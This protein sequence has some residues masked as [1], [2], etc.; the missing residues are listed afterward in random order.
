MRANSP[1]IDTDLDISPP[2]AQGLLPFLPRFWREYVEQSSFK[3]PVEAPFGTVARPMLVRDGLRPA[4]SRVPGADLGLLREQALDAWGATYGILNCAYEVDSIHNPDAAA[5][6]A[7]A[8]NDWQAAEWLAHEPRLRASLVVPARWPELAAREVR[9]WAGRPGFVQ[10]LLPAR[11]ESPYGN[12]RYHPLYAAAV[13]QGLTIG[14]HFGGEPGNPP[15]ASGW[16]SYGIEEYVGMASVF[17]SQLISLV[18][19]GAF[20]QFPGLRVALLEG[21]FTW[22]PSLMWRMDKEWK[23]LRREIP[24]VRQPPSELIRQHVRCSLQPLDAPPDSEHLRQ[25]I[26][27]IQCDELLMFSSAFPHAHFDTAEQALPA[28]LPPELERRIR[29]DNAHA[30]YPW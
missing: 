3:G 13:E 30:F 16:F 17:Q 26:A 25:V 9:R 21:G 7:A 1:L 10:V 27:Q 4:D 11:S 5:A 20:A 15:S 2:P 18:A 29:F 22:L 14:I 23:G 24:W 12:R 6:M 19:E 28:G 8:L